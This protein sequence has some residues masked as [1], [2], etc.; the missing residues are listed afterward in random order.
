VPGGAGEERRREWAAD[1]AVF[2]DNG[3]TRPPI[4][5]YARA[6]RFAAGQ[7]R[8]VRRLTRLTGVRR[9]RAVTVRAAV[10]A[11][12]AA[13]VLFITAIAL[14]PPARH[15]EDDRSPLLGARSRAAFPPRG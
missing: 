6:V 8:A 10:V 2:F 9:L 14:S 7:R 5:R 13:A 12:A 11:A 4:R 1:R 15:A 3:A